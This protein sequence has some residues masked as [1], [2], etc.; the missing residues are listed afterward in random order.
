MITYPTSELEEDAEGREDD[1]EDDVDAGGGA[2]DRSSFLILM[3]RWWMRWAMQNSGAEQADGVEKRICPG[4]PYIDGERSQVWMDG[5][6]E[7]ARWSRGETGE[8]G[9]NIRSTRVGLKTGTRW[10]PRRRRV[11]K[12][13]G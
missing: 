2:H 7:S 1:G 13:L 9:D 10:R 11:I 6:G 4:F 12:T 8:G 3:S 5:D